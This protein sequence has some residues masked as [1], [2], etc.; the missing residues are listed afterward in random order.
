M[1]SQIFII[2]LSLCFIT[3]DYAQTT[4]TDPIDISTQSDHVRSVYAADLDNDG[5]V[6]VLYAS[7]DYDKIAWYENDGNGNFGSQKTITNNADGA[8]T[9]YTADLDND[10]DLDVLSASI[11]DDKIAWYENDGNGNF[12]SQEIITT[13]A[14]GAVSVYA[15]DLDNDGDMDVLSSSAYDDKIAW[16][17]NT[18]NGNFG[19]EEVIIISAY[20]VSG[21]VNAA[22]LDNDGDMDVLSGFN[23]DSGLLVVW[24]ANDG[25]GNFGSQEIIPTTYPGGLTTTFAAD[26]DNDGRIDVLSA[27]YRASLVGWNKNEGYGNFAE[28]QLITQP[29][30]MFPVSVYAADLDNDGDLDVLLASLYG[31]AI[32]WYENDGNG[33]FGSREIL[34]GSIYH[35]A[36]SVYA[37]DLDNDGDVD[38]LSS[39]DYNKIVW[40]KNN[41][42][43]YLQLENQIGCVNTQQSF[44]VQPSS[45][46]AF[47]WQIKNG[48]TYEDLIDNGQYSGTTTDSLLISEISMEINNNHYRCQLTYSDNLSTESNDAI[49]TVLPSPIT[50]N[51]IGKPM[52]DP[53][54]TCTYS[55]SL[56]AGSTYEWAVEGG[57]IFSSF[58]NTV[59]ILWAE[60]GYGSLTVTETDSNTC[61]GVPVELQIIIDIQEIANKYNI[62][63]FPNPS[64]GELYIQGDNI[65]LIELF[66]ST[67]QYLKTIPMDKKQTNIDFSQVAKGVYF[68]KFTLVDAVFTEKLILK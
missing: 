38:V 19:S 36:K 51:I 4:F 27:S 44:T 66:S 7:M 16:Y 63:I 32:A 6:D 11:Y 35:G 5:D 33:N 2:V 13:N 55:V 26:L 12:G 68:I 40:Y 60:E 49:L 59:Q 10:G 29:Y 50:D 25:N 46:T 9:V 31:F 61:V 30:S 14:A 43:S 54:E 67:G 48:N 53:Y 37:A 28:Q 39:T 58:Q 42:Y 62:Q 22:D 45:A 15:A 1:K 34:P 8:V 3:S 65:Q 23:S 17:E 56:T 64:N 18:G 20:N 21:P 24:Y 47:Q 52:P 41:Y 57:G